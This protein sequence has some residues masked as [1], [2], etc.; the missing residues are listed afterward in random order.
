[1]LQLQVTKF[2][3]FVEAMKSVCSGCLQ[4]C[5]VNSTKVQE[6]LFCISVIKRT[7]EHECSLRTQGQRAFEVSSYNE[8]LRVA[9]SLPPVYKDRVCVEKITKMTA[10]ALVLLL[11]CLLLLFLLALPYLVPIPSH[12]LWCKWHS[13]A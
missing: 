11:S 10:K 13:Y 12:L 4:D 2:L 5:Y 8:F 9:T 6:S 1:M 3:L 7:V